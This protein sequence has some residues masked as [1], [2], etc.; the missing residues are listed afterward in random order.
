VFALAISFLLALLQTTPTGT[1][2]GAVKLPNDVKARPA[3]RVVLLPPKYIELW[4]RQVQTRLDNYWELFKPD[5]AANKERFSDFDRIA[6]LESLRY[7]TSTMRRELGDSASTYIQ[8]SFDGQFKLDHVPLGT[9]QLLVQS[10]ING[11]DVIWSKSIDVLTEVPIFVDLGK[12]V[13]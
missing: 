10:S 2:V 1:V 5:F 13:S 12:P 6:Q 11:R 8:E 9:Y 4:D 3:T 7:I